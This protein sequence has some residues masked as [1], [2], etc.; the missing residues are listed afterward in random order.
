MSLAL[1]EHDLEYTSFK[2]SS[3]HALNTYWT[4]KVLYAKQPTPNPEVMFS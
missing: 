2:H 3:K 1:N 4:W